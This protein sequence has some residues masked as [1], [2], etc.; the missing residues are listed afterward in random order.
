MAQ[1]TRHG[2]YGGPRGVV[3]FSGKDPL[4]ETLRL[5]IAAQTWSKVQPTAGTWEKVQPVAQNWSAE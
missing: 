1:V 3:D 4:V 5:Y 2:L